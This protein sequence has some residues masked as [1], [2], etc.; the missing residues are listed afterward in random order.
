MESSEKQWKSETFP[1][2]VPL[3]YYKDTTFSGGKQIVLKCGKHPFPSLFYRCFRSSLQFCRAIAWKVVTAGLQNTGEAI[4]SW[5]C[6]ALCSDGTVWKPSEES[7]RT[8]RLQWKCQGRF[9]NCPHRVP[10][11]WSRNRTRLPHKRPS[12]H[13]WWWL[14]VRHI[15]DHTADGL[16]RNRNSSLQVPPQPRQSSNK[17]S[18]QSRDS[19]NRWCEASCGWENI[20]SKQDMSLHGTSC[21]MYLWHKRTSR[22]WAGSWCAAHRT[23][24]RPWRPSSDRWRWRKEWFPCRLR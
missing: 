11:S 18:A 8:L 19:R 6:L 13:C 5:D 9:R 20:P 23:A 21:C 10:A 14:R 4:S 16:H 12:G 22:S 17:P 7:I 2:K 15:Q 1:W 3:C 24:R